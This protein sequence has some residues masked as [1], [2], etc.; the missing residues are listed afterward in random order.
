MNFF[1][2][3]RLQ[4]VTLNYSHFNSFTSL[5]LRSV[6]WRAHCAVA[7][8]DSYSGEL[9]FVWWAA[10]PTAPPPGAFYLVRPLAANSSAP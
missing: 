9:V 4:T 2:H 1:Q 7:G 6:D 3:L 10:A 8:G 5:R